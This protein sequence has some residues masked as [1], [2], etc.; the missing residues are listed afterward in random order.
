M[1]AKNISNLIKKKNAQIQEVQQTPSR[2]MRKI[3]L[4]HFKIILLKTS[5]KRE[6]LKADGEKTHA[7]NRATK[8]KV[9]HSSLETI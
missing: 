3:T 7:I 4:K 5:S 9:R 8:V 2:R 6:I 1:K